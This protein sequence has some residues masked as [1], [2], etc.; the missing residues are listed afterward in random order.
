MRLLVSGCRLE[1]ARIEEDQSSVFMSAWPAFRSYVFKSLSPPEKP[2][3]MNHDHLGPHEA[4]LTTT[5]GSLGWEDELWRGCVEDS[6]L[7]AFA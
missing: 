4:L 7:L 3:C 1:S 6:S 5:N 2:P